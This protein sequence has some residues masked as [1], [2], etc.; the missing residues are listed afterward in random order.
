MTVLMTGC[1]VYVPIAD[2]NH[3]PRSK[4][5]AQISDFELSAIRALNA[6]EGSCETERNRHN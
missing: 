1:A 4:Y 5:E 6:L 3:T 2:I